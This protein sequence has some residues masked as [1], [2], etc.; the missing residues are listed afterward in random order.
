MGMGI[1]NCICQLWPVTE[2]NRQEHPAYEV[3]F[4]P[5]IS[6][7][8]NMKI[9]SLFIFFISTISISAQ[10]FWKI[11]GVETDANALHSG[12][13]YSHN[14]EAI[15]ISTYNMGIF[16]SADKGTSWDHVLDLPKDQ[17]VTE[18]GLLIFP[19]PFRDKLS[20]RLNPKESLAA[21]TQYS[22]TDFSGKLLLIG[23]QEGD[24]IILDLESLE[25]GWYLLNVTQ[26]QDSEYFKILKGM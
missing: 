10:S 24:L 15:F 1:N 13:L 2:S 9:V 18:S 11:S 20:I 26:S 8:L 22:I 14:P 12:I 4:S 21:K 7:Q 5:P 16:R 23:E 6:I 17:P 3:I 25:P 19:I